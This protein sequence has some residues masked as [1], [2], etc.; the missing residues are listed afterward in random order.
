MYDGQCPK[1]MHSSFQVESQR[2]LVDTATVAVDTIGT[3]SGRIEKN[4]QKTA[5]STPLQVRPK[6]LSHRHF[7]ISFLMFL[8]SP[9]MCA[10][11]TAHGDSFR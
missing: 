10:K 4:H 11:Y 2:R 6:D 1:D 8:L 9:S 5:A 3:F 7:W